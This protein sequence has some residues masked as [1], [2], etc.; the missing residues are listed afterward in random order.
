MPKRK[1][2][3]E[4]WI[5]HAMSIEDVKEWLTACHHEVKSEHTEEHL[6]QE[7]ICM[8]KTGELKMKDLLPGRIDW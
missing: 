7:L 4:R 1:Y 8:V 2:S 3:P 6:R 5:N